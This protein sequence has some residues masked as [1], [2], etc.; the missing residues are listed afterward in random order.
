MS[1][2][3]LCSV[4]LALVVF[5]VTSAACATSQTSAGKPGAPAP[6]GDCVWAF[7]QYEPSQWEREWFEGEESGARRNRECEILA[8]P[9]EVDRS[10]R[11]IRATQGA[12]LDSKP[13]PQ[14][15]IELFSRMVYAEQ[16]GA[17]PRETGRRRAQLIEPLVGIVRDPLTI[18]PRAPGI[19]DDIYDSFQPDEGRIQA[20][21]HFLIGVAAPWSETPNDPASW[22]L[23]S[24]EPYAAAPRSDR[25]RARLNFL[26]DMG[27]STYGNWGGDTT[28]V[29][30]AWLV[31]RNK[32]H[33][34]AFDWIVSFEYAKVDPE[35]IYSS[36]PASI[37]PHYIYF[38]RPVESDPNGKW[39]PWR[40]LRGMGA[41]PEDYVVVKIDIDS[42]DIENPLLDQVAGD[43]GLQHLV[44]ELFI[45]HHVNATLMNG[46]WGTGNSQL[47]MR[48]TYQKFTTLRSK[49]VRMHSW[50]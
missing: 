15:S 48:D 18:C 30:A 20:K 16:C 21:R 45:E 2:R 49:G 50:P 8:T 3:V 5:A 35:A 10:V 28:A 26:V 44:D 11:L 13:I 23:G 6:Q 17:S 31:E 39:N 27:A 38:D 42:P 32:R 43:N 14:E 19:P 4:R 29:G 37:L 47:T 22:R 46:W 34:L 36:V 33:N 24:F 12:V 40:I 1:N 9:P 41:R 7:V 25:P